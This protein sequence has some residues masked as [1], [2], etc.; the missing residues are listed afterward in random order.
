[1]R[2]KLAVYKVGGGVEGS[3]VIYG[4]DYTVDKL[5]AGVDRQLLPSLS[6]TDTRSAAGNDRN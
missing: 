3:T 2:D 5:P 4:E 1:M 6:D